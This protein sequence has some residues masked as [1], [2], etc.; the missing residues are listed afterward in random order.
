MGDAKK[1][2][3]KAPE[4]MNTLYIC[5]QD[6]EKIF[7]TKA[8]Y[9]QKARYGVV[10]TPLVETQAMEIYNSLMEGGA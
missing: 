2:L 5:S 7:D 6:S 10:G 8:E 1:D 4:F 9:I 3:E